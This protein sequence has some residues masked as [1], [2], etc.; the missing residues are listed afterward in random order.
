MK[1]KTRVMVI[2]LILVLA[3][4]AGFWLKRQLAI[5]ICLDGGGLWNYSLSQ[6]EK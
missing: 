5:D 4:A 3:I 1:K 2:V 6:C